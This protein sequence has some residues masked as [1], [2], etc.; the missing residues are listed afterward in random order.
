[1]ERNE[2]ERAVPQCA[3]S[4]RDARDR[5][6]MGD[7]FG[8]VTTRPMWRML[9]FDDGKKFTMSCQFVFLFDGMKEQRKKWME[10]N[11]ELVRCLWVALTRGGGGVGDISRCSH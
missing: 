5:N 10:Q 11:S 9:R 2:L 3:L 1:M 6:G 7:V 8:F 4:M